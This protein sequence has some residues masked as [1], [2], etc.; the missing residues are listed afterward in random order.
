[1]SLYL[2]TELTIVSVKTFVTKIFTTIYFYHEIVQRL[3]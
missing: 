2:A 1:V 3:I